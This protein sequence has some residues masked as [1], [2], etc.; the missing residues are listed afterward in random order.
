MRYRLHR[1]MRDPLFRCLLV[2]L[3]AIAIVM[4][5]SLPADSATQDWPTWARWLLGFV[6]GMAVGIPGR[7]IVL[8]IMKK[9]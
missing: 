2:L 7:R 5:I 8:R 6:I 9:G 4:A 1:L 3:A